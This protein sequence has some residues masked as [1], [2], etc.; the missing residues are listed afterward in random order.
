MK[1]VHIAYSPFREEVTAHDR[2]LRVFAATPDP[3]VT[4]IDELKEWIEPHMIDLLVDLYRAMDGAFKYFVTLYVSFTDVKNDDAIK[5]GF[6]MTKMRYCYSINAAEEETTRSLDELRAQD[7]SRAT[8]DATGS[9]WVLRS[10]DAIHINVTKYQSYMG[11]SKNKKL[12]TD[13]LPELIVNKKCL[14]I[15]QWTSHCLFHCIAAS[16]V[17]SHDDSE[18]ML[19]KETLVQFKSVTAVSQIAEIEK[20]WKI[21]I[22]VY[23]FNDDYDY[24]F[25]VRI[26]DDIEMDENP[27]NDKIVNV[28][29]YNSHYYL[30]KNFNSFAGCGGKRVNKYCF[31]CLNSFLTV[32]ACRRHMRIC[33]T[34]TPAALNVPTLGRFGDLPVVKFYRQSNCFHQPYVVY[35]DFESLLVPQANIRRGKNSTVTHQH[36]TFA[37]AYVLINDNSD[38]VLQKMYIQTSKTTAW[39][40]NGFAKTGETIQVTLSPAAS[41]LQSLFDVYRVFEEMITNNTPIDLSSVNHEEYH[42]ATRCHICKNSFKEDAFG[43]TDKVRDHNHLNGRYRGAAH[44]SCNLQYKPTQWMT[45]VMHNLTNYDMH[46]LIAALGEIKDQIA[47]VEVIPINSEKYSTMNVVTTSGAKIRFIDS[48]RFLNSSLETLST[49]L[50][51]DKQCLPLLKRFFPESHELLKGKQVFPYEFL[52]SFDALRETSLPSQQSF[53]NSLTKTSTSDDDYQHAKQVWNSTNCTTMTDYVRIYLWTDV[54][55][56]A[57]VFENFRTTSLKQ[58]SLD[59]L[60]YI[61]MPHFAFDAA[62]LMTGIK[63]EL[64]IDIDQILFVKEGIRGGVSMI[65]HRY[66]KAHNP[67]IDSNDTKMDHDKYIIYADIN[68]L[69]GY[70]MSEHLPIGGFKWIDEKHF[71]D[72]MGKIVNFSPHTSK[73]GWIVEL[74]LAYPDDLHDDHND[75]PL[76]P[77]KIKIDDSN[78][79]SYQIRMREGK[80]GLSKKLVPHFMPRNHYVVHFAALRYYIDNGMIPGKIH[81]ILQFKQ[82]PWLEPYIEMNTK[83][84]QQSK[85]PFERD[86]YKLMNNAVYGKTM[87]NLWNRHEVKICWTK[88]QL[89]KMS[90]KPWFRCFQI[91]D[92][93]VSICVMKKRRIFLNK[94]LYLGMSI[95][96]ISKV[97][98][99]RTFYEGFKTVWPDNMKLLMVDTDSYI[100]EITTPKGVSIYKQLYDYM[101]TDM[102]KE[103]MFRLDCSNYD[104]ADDDESIALLASQHACDRQ[105]GAVKD[106]MGSTIITEFIGLRPK[107][108]AI[109]KRHRPSNATEEIIKAKGTPKA[110]VKTS[111]NFQHFS[112]MMRESMKSLS[113]DVTHIRSREHN[114]GTVVTKKRCLTI[115]DDKR[116]IDP[117]EHISTLALGHK[118]IRRHYQDN[119]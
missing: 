27:A 98:F 51:R 17:L 113:F 5:H 50:L 45:V 29:L 64:M 93:D 8:S 37:Y 71:D 87:E 22:N 114:I 79:S 60:H 9:Q 99:Y 61:S 85:S 3:P 35:A 67:L 74:D 28:F 116:F 66:S 46:P 16:G 96:D 1:A 30:I 62:L 40:S 88:E 42:K 90:D 108:Y 13:E 54:L 109:R 115:A 11:G 105:L 20:I 65:S 111:I 6:L 57:E 55:L 41:M 97:V 84:R 77:E 44:E 26:N 70:A 23:S 7:A 91:V 89:L 63:L 33:R 118:K 107:L 2:F 92:K 15:E 81:R 19:C 106:E 80:A 76:A 25:P 94:P 72:I 102:Y 4:S 56:L 24:I 68:N 73:V 69:Y 48:M 100:M 34:N 104:E 31:F 119:V 117:E 52:T 95:L 75:L 14:H 12:Q 82:E 103:G 112:D 18:K 47:S 39:Q 110:V 101:Q 59:P 10:I 49:S 21:G 83:L 43:E 53:F 78:L 38:A 36:D 32:D 86:M 58:Y